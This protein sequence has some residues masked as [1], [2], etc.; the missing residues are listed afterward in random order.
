VRWRDPQTL[1]APLLL[2]Y[3]TAISLVFSGQ[4]RYHAPLMP[5]VIG[6]AAW[7][8]ARLRRAR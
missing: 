4:S 1:V 3:F 8:L 7:T 5:F 2:L 6:Y